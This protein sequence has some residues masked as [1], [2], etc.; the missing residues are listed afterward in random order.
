[1]EHSLVGWDI[2]KLDEI[3]WVPW[4]SQGNAKAKVLA[5]A[6]GHHVVLVEA[7]AGYAG[8]PHVRAFPEFL[9]VLEG[10]VRTQGR[11]MGPG[12]AYAAATGSTHSDFET[13]S[14]ATYLSI[15]KL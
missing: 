14:G 12:E 8:D 3:E 1:M 7:G 13:E 2:S 10:T 11:T 4:G 15:F 6:D 5:A 9:Y